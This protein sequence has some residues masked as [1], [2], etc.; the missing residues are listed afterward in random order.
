RRHTRSKRDWSSDVCSSDLVARVHVVENRV[1]VVA[2]LHAVRRELAYELGVLDAFAVLIVF[3]GLR[4]IDP[5][6]VVH[7]L[8]RKIRRQAFRSEERRV[9]KECS[10]WWSL[11]P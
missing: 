3:A 8:L 9:G 6:P 7:Q 11:E 10:P 2:F 4:G 1:E 5:A